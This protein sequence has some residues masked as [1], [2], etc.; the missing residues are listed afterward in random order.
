MKSL[1]L[2][3]LTLMFICSLQGCSVISAGNESH[4]YWAKMGTPAKIVDIKEIKIIIK[5]EN[6]KEQVSNASLN[7]M[8]SIDQ[9][10]L[11]YYLQLHKLYGDQY[12]KSINNK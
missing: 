4:T 12:L 11:E 3:C 6:G 2:T 9:P 8:M 7:G 5:D 1:A 10:T